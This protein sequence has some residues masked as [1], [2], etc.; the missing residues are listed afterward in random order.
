MK[1]LFICMMAFATLTS[2]DK[3]KETLTSAKEATAGAD[4]IDYQFL[5]KPEETKKWYDEIVKRSGEG[6]KVMDEVSFNIYR[7]SL[8]GMIQRAGEKDHLYLSIVYQDNVDKRRVEEIQYHGNS[9]G[10]TQPE[11]KDIQV[12]GIGAENFKLEDELYDFG[13][14]SLETFNKVMADALKKYKDDA[15]YE[16]QYISSVFIK[17][18]GFDVSVKGKLKSNSQLKTET[19]RT[20]LKG[21][22]Q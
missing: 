2:C 13:Q 16:Y 8:E 20:D 14:V 6:A 19:Y 10:W 17:K 3:I 5:S 4:E 1:K 22:E 18:S 15:K 11:K 9:S 12:T 21:N 7:P